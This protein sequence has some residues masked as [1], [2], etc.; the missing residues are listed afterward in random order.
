[1]TIL[2][3]WLG[4][5]QTSEN[6][7]AVGVS[8][9]IACS[10]VKVVRSQDL[11]FEIADYRLAIDSSASKLD[12]LAAK[13]DRA[14]ATIQEKDAAYARLEEVYRLSLKGKKGYGKL[15][16]AIEEVESISPVEDIDRLKTEIIETKQ[17]LE[18]A[19]GD[20]DSIPKSNGNL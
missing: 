13:L 12:E 14:T 2:A 16:Q 5:S 17:T 11:A 9:F 20:R 1:M 8:V 4:L 15:Q 18:S 7:L 6:I 10:G 19:V 3:D